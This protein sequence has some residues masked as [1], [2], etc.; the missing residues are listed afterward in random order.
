MNLHS[1]IIFAFA[2]SG[3]PAEV[4]AMIPSI[5]EL[6]VKISSYNPVHKL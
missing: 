5:T 3:R 2:C 6:A 4:D 1:A